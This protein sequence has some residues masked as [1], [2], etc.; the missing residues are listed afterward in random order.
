MASVRG[1]TTA[2]AFC[3]PILPLLARDAAARS[4]SSRRTVHGARL[5]LPPDAPGP[6]DAAIPARLSIPH[7]SSMLLS[8][9]LARPNRHPPYRCRPPRLRP[10]I[11][12]PALFA[13][14]DSASAA[15]AAPLLNP[16]NKQMPLS[17]SDA[18]AAAAAPVTMLLPSPRPA[19]LLCGL[20]GFTSLHDST[21]IP[22]RDPSFFRAAP[23][24]DRYG[25][26]RVAPSSPNAT[27][28]LYHFL[29]LLPA[30]CRRH[31][32]PLPLPR[33][34]REPV[35]FP[36]ADLQHKTRRSSSCLRPRLAPLLHLL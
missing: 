34:S 17:S 25:C 36:V 22:L 27:D 23:A 35:T 33:H 10:C 6:L 19:P 18:A 29:G 2:A 5:S 13:D 3:T 14:M 24:P 4:C 21:R 12:R 20:H 1:S 31:R 9:S 11:P 15:A 16:A 7:V 8:R 30:L 28:T 26:R 32:L